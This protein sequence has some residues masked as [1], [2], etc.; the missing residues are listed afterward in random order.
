V[1]TARGERAVVPPADFPVRSV[2]R[3]T[4]TIG[5]PDKLKE[6]VDKVVEKI[7]EIAKSA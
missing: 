3:F 4:P 2:F 5:I 1:I 6:W 7:R